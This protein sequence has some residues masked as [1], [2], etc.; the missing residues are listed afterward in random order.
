L[1]SVAVI[2]SDNELAHSDFADILSVL[3]KPL[4]LG[5]K[6]RDYYS[7]HSFDKYNVHR[8]FQKGDEH[9]L[10]SFDS[11]IVA[12]NATND[13]R[14]LGILV[15]NKDLLEQ[16]IASGKGVFVSSQKKLSNKTNETSGSIQFLPERYDYCIY[17][18]PEQ[19]SGEG[20]VTVCNPDDVLMSYPSKIDDALIAYHCEN[21][22]FMQHWYRS[23]IVPKDDSR[24]I[25]L[26][27]DEKA[28]LIPDVLKDFTE[29]HRKVLLRT[30]SFSERVVVSTMALDWA[31]HDELL[32]N[33][34]IYITEGIS[35]FAFIR[36]ADA[37]RDVMD[38][39]IVR[40]K[41]AKMPFREYYDQSVSDLMELSHSVFIFSPD[42]EKRLIEQFWKECKQASKKVLIYK[43]EQAT[44]G[45][46]LCQ[47]TTETSAYRMSLE[48][49][50][51]L[52]R[53]FYPDFWGKSIWTYN[54][55]LLMMIDLHLD[56][57]P[58]LDY[59]YSDL[60][61]H[62]CHKDGMRTGSYD[63]VPNATCMMLEILHFVYLSLVGKSYKMYIAHPISSVFNE[64]RD[65]VISKLSSGEPRT[66]QDIVYMLHTLFKIDY[67]QESDSIQ[68]FACNE[69]RDVIS[70]YR[71]ANYASASSVILCKIAFI[72]LSLKQLGEI[73]PGVAADQASEIAQI[74]IA[75]QSA[76]G[77]W[78]NISETAEIALLLLQIRL[79]DE[80]LFAALQNQVNICVV[81]A[82]EYLYVHYNHD[83]YNWIDDVGT[84]AKAMHA[85]GLFD[86]INN[87]SV[88][89]FFVDV[90]LR[91][92]SH[93]GSIGLEQSSKALQ[94]TLYEIQ[95]RETLLKEAHSEKRALKVDIENHRKKKSFFRGLFFA[96]FVTTVILSGLTLLI[97]IGLSG[98]PDV[99]KDLFNNW[100]AEFIFG[101]FGVVVGLVFTGVYSYVKKNLFDVDKQSDI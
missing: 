50:N 84:T 16:F 2:V 15:E 51:W 6:K 18:R 21:N 98:Y 67:I 9:S 38:S 59:I 70:Y 82:M 78:R 20:I 56:C 3:E 55:V 74:L 81:N 36:G 87:L 101:Y 30:G 63:R 85:I 8:L 28:D 71:N 35:P 47:F 88:N 69:A 73:P 94:R 79:K 22:D 37:T 52:S 46:E 4:T 76:N 17:D 49:E 99:L 7:F 66:R 40:A 58:Y 42:C 29:T 27:A 1:F 83:E 89:D 68:S 93:L 19:S 14:L 53:V 23:F 48:V 64:T 24:Y 32:E 25:T 13:S 39:Y 72:I 62:F 75:K 10:A 26:L 11:V 33:I 43:L 54:Y 12:T 100:K 41:A 61:K 60:T 97:F 31:S 96:F 65:W 34:L 90:S 86:T 92:R 95:K 5:D 57:A 80:V 44:A 91:S 77:E 45:L